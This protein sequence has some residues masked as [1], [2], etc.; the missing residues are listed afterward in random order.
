MVN[1]TV[2]EISYNLGLYGENF[3]FSYYRIDLDW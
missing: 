2:Y 1:G 3:T